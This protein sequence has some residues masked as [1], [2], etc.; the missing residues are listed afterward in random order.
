MN[1][2]DVS[3]RLEADGLRRLMTQAPDIVIEELTTGVTEASMLAEREIRERTPTS[4][5]GTLRESI[6]AMPVEF[7]QEVVRGGV[8]TSLPYAVP[9]ETGS[10]PHMPPISPLVDWVER[11]LGLRDKE[12]QGVAWAIARKIAKQ[13]TQGAFMFRDG[14]AA[15]EPQIMAI[16]GAAIER[17]TA[18]IAA[19]ER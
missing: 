16:L 2:P 3:V 6:G 19:G 14:F 9:V 12:A 11:K 15:V 8:A 13:G 10:K 7:A 5:A 18:R 1:E 17:A 4:G